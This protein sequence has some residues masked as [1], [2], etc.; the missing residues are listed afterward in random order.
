MAQKK[1]SSTVQRNAKSGKFTVRSATGTTVRSA[2][3]T[4]KSKVA[5]KSATTT[6]KDALKRL[7]KK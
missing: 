7:A 2:T 5:I 6:H 1:T 3:I 4:A